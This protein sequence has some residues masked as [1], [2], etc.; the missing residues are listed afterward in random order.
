MQTSVSK[1]SCLNVVF[2]IS[3]NWSYAK[4]FTIRAEMNESVSGEMSCERIHSDCIKLVSC[5]ILKKGLNLQTLMCKEL[6]HL[7]K[8]TCKQLVCDA[9]VSDF[10][11]LT[12][13]GSC[14]FSPVKCTGDILTL[15]LIL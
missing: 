10:S 7:L 6:I 15:S 9:S 12:N 14:G 13:L 2:K 3:P 1:Q 5:C 8:G 11:T 4:K